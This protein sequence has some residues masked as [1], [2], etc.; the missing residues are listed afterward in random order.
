MKFFVFILAIELLFRP[1]LDRLEG[2]EFILWYGKKF[3]NY[4]ILF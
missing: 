3:R 4:I 2:G 1:R